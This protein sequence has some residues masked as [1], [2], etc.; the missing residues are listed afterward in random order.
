MEDLNYEE[1][2]D[3]L[4]KDI[5][6]DIMNRLLAVAGEKRITTIYD[7]IYA[8]EQLNKPEYYLVANTAH[9][10]ILDEFV[11]E[12]EIKLKVLYSPLMDENTILV[13]K[14]DGTLDGSVGHFEMHYPLDPTQ[15]Y[16]NY[17]FKLTHQELATKVVIEDVM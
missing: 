1:I 5:D 13:V 3:K 6:T 8:I 2:F 17:E 15:I 10:E 16:M 9:R 7:I 12:Q 14:N 4:A 11:K